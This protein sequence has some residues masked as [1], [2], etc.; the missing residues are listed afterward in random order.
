MRLPCR[1]VFSFLDTPS[2]WRRGK[3]ERQEES[4]FCEQATAK[5]PRRKEAK[6]F[7]RWQPALTTSARH[8]TKIFLLLFFQKKK[9]LASCRLPCFFALFVA[10][11]LRHCVGG[12]GGM[13]FA[14]SP[15][16]AFSC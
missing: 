11:W 1:K 6:N 5:G 2:T 3:G 12:G 9:T 7:T 15:D 16:D 8:V 4:S 10:S 14:F 13:R